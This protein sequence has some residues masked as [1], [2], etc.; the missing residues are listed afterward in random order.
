MKDIFGGREVVRDKCYPEDFTSIGVPVPKR[1]DK[2]VM[3]KCLNCGRIFPMLKKN[4]AEKNCR[5]K[6]CLVTNDFIK[7]DEILS[8]IVVTCHY[9]TFEYI[10]DTY[11]LDMVSK[12]KWR[13]AIKRRKKYLITGTHKK[14]TAIYLHQM[15]YGE[16]A[17]KGFTIDHRNSNEFDNT[18]NNLC[19]VTTTQNAQNVNARYTNK[20][21]IRGVWWSTRDN[22]YG[23]S[24][25]VN[26]TSYYFKC[27]KTLKEAVLCRFMAEQYFGLEIAKRNP[28]VLEIIN[29]STHEELS[30]MQEY[31]INNIERKRKSAENNQE[32]RP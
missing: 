26:G 22:Y 18:R 23:S 3:A 9:G 2:Y 11:N 17:P 12:Y 21:G 13:I 10:I 4:L 25:T 16:N 30:Q 24:I 27:C 8:K 31:V 28:K 15:I 6:E 7:V 19:L 5:C 14:K 32:S 29:E 20:L 1:I